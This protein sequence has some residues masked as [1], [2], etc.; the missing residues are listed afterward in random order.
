MKLEWNGIE[1]I[2][3][4]D[5]RYENSSDFVDDSEHVE[6]AAA[7]KGVM[8]SDTHDMP[9][10]SEEREYAP[11]RVDNLSELIERGKAFNK[12]RL[13]EEEKN[14]EM[15]RMQFTRSIAEDE[16]VI[17]NKN[18]SMKKSKGKVEGSEKVKLVDDQLFDRNDFVSPSRTR[19]SMKT[20]H[21]AYPFVIGHINERLPSTAS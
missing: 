15:N 2:V 8:Q 14:V 5:S 6:S 11:R 13:A 18:T 9:K 4:A 16:A 1:E 12:R 3:D 19:E 17:G 10:L 21:N 7:D 20:H